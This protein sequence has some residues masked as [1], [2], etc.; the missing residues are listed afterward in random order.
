[1]CQEIILVQHMQA[2]KVLLVQEIGDV[3]LVVCSVVMIIL[4][5]M[6]LLYAEV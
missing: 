1:M 2:S 5:S 3:K 6:I 4:I